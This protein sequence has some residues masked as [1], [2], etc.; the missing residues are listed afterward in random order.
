MDASVV[1]R[2]ASRKS[3]ST[4]VSVDDEDCP[5]KTRPIDGVSVVRRKS[6]MVNHGSA[7]VSVIQLED[8][9]KTRSADVSVYGQ[10][11]MRKTQSIGDVCVV[12]SR[13]CQ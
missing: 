5:R 7:S 1:G 11:T 4:D 2:K 6:C 12:M 3:R 8:P 13:E 9:C 10:T